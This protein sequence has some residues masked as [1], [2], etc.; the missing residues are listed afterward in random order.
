MNQWLKRKEVCIDNTDSTNKKKKI[1]TI[2][3]PSTSFGSSTS[4]SLVSLVNIND[5]D[6]TSYELDIAY[7]LKDSNKICSDHDRATL[8]T[9]DNLPKTDFV[10]PFSVHMK[11]GK[12]EKRYLNKSYFEKYKWLTFS[13]TMSGLYC[14]FCVLF[15]DKGGRYKTVTLSKFVS[16][17]LQKYSKLLRKD[18]NLEVHSKHIY[19]INCV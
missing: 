1:E 2:V 13:K 5:I 3:T 12:E 9:M 11:K 8:I 19:H 4:N 18:G 10:L 17:P 14:K 16:K 6:S 15:G 7:F